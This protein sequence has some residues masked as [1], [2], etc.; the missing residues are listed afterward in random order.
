[1][2][3]QYDEVLCEYELVYL[4]HNRAVIA[5][6][7]FLQHHRLPVHSF[8]I[9]LPDVIKH[10]IKKATRECDLFSRELIPMMWIR[11][12]TELVIT[13]KET[14]LIPLLDTE[15][16]LLVNEDVFELTQGAAYIVRPGTKIEVKGEDVLLL[17][18]L[19]LLD[20]GQ[21]GPIELMLP[22]GQ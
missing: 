18:P 13:D 3:A 9:M 15:G 4:K 8:N 7:E 14:L 21:E 5:A 12:D 19:A 20:K 22:R 1:M 17:G 10:S 16:Y 11:G 2:L 6:E